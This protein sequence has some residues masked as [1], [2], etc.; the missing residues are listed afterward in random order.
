MLHI[1]TSRT[2]GE[3]SYSSSATLGNHI[4]WLVCAFGP[5]F[6][7]ILFGSKYL[8]ATKALHLTH[9]FE[10]HGDG[11]LDSEKANWAHSLVYRGLES[12]IARLFTDYS[13]QEQLNSLKFLARAEAGF[14]R[15]LSS[16]LPPGAN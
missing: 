14:I 13:G 1:A 3:N 4:Q 12:F 7:V 6:I 15:L 2:S 11:R 10:A 5:S 16:Q 8:E 9:P